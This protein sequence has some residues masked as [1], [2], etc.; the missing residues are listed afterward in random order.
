[1]ALTDE[2]S[3]VQTIRDHYDQIFSAE[4][5]WPISSCPIRKKLSTPTYLRWR[6]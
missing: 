6:S 5:K 4:K 2:R 3:V 1:M